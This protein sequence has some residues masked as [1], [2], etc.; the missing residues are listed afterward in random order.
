MESKNHQEKNIIKPK[1]I[2]YPV[3]GK[4]LIGNALKCKKCS[5]AIV[6]RCY[7]PKQTLFNSHD[8]SY[9]SGIDNQICSCKME[10]EKRLVEEKE[11]KK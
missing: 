6:F 10:G 2:H 11:Q 5:G 3:D 7:Y 8:F 1:S 9:R 4:H